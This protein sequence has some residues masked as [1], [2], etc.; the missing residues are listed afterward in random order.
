MEIVATNVVVSQPPEQRP[1]ATSTPSVRKVENREKK[2]GEKEDN[3]G[4]SGHQ[5]HCQST[6]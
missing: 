5:R 6:G 1:T 3:D 4:N 2:E